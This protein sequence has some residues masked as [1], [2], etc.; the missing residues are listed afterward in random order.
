MKSALNRDVDYC[1]EGELSGGG[2]DCV[3]EWDW[4]VLC[5]F[6][7][8]G[9]T[10]AFLDCAGDALRDEQPPWDYV[11]IPW[12]DYHIYGLV[13]YVSFDDLAIHNVSA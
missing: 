5:D 10:G 7:E 12:V 13:E 11:S 1:F 4:A 6:A 2:E 8:R 9:K 3:S